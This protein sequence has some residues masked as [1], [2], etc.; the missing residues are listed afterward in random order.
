MFEVGAVKGWAI[1]PWWVLAAFAVLGAIPAWWIVEA[2]GFCG[3]EDVDDDEDESARPDRG[4]PEEDVGAKPR[5]ID[6]PEATK[7]VDGPAIEA[8]GLLSVDRLPKTI[9]KD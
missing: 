4:F 8:Q 3:S 6:P 9:G 1:L 7:R 2:D 5:A